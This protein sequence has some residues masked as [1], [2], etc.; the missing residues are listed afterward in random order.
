MLLLEKEMKFSLFA[1]YNF[2][3]NR[4]QNQLQKDKYVFWPEITLFAIHPHR[5]PSVYIARG[6]CWRFKSHILLVASAGSLNTVLYKIFFCKREL[7]QDFYFLNNIF[8]LISLV[9]AVQKVQFLNIF[10]QPP[11]PLCS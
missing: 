5:A 10:F 8:Q 1:F 6:Q 3:E 4:L 2:L 11:P 9:A 7:S